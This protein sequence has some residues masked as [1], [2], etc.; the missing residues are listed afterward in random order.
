MWDDIW[1]RIEA[2]IGTVHTS[3]D[4]AL[5]MEAMEW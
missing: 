4:V 5:L 2:Y 3:I 1:D